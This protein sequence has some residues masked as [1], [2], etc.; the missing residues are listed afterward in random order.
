MSDSK[1]L[2]VHPPDYD[3]HISFWKDF[4]KVTI[5]FLRSE[6]I[7][8]YKD[9][10][11]RS[12]RAAIEPSLWKMSETNGK[13]HIRYFSR[14][15]WER[16]LKEGRLPSKTTG[17]WNSSRAELMFEHVVERA[18][19]VEWILED[20]SNIDIIEDICIGCI[21]TKSESKLLPNRCGVDPKNV[22][23][24]YLEKKIDVYDRMLK[25]WHILDG[26]L[27]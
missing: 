7:R 6:G 5:N 20:P 16:T 19:I 1:F 23:K 25:K 11:K 14:E 22:W 10:R 26:K 24:R 2:Y 15:T 21:V 12:A 4:L 13:Y 17:S 8:Q 18:P 3:R 9:L 27:V